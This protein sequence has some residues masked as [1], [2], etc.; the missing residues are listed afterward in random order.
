MVAGAA[1]RLFQRGRSASRERTRDSSTPQ[2]VLEPLK[3]QRHAPPAPP[4]LSKASQA[5]CPGILL[6]P[7][8]HAVIPRDIDAVKRA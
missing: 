1:G 7:G 2:W 3:A 8:P 4:G 5:L 6:I